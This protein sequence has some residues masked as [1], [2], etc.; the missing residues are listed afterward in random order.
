MQHQLHH[1]K[2]ANGVRVLCIPMPG[3]AAVTATVLFSVG[4]RYESDKQRGLAHFTEHMV[5]KG[6]IN[7]PDAQSIAQA[8]DAVGGEFNAFTSQ[9]Y[10]GF[11]TKTAGEHLELGLSVL[12]DMLLHAQFSQQEL[13]KEKGVIVEEINMYEDMPMRKVD[14]VL[15]ELVYGQTALGLPIIGSKESVTAFTPADFL[16]YR[17]EFY[18]GDAC[19]IV[20][21]G[22]VQPEVAHQLATQFFARM[23]S[24]SAHAADS[25]QFEPS[26][27]PVLI[28]EK[29]SEQTHLLLAVEGL[30]FS[31]PQRYA[32]RVLA[33][34]L[35][36]N[37]S[38]RLFVSVR[39]QQG[40]CYYVRA[41]PDV[42]KDTGMLVASAGVDNNRAE[43]AVQAIVKEMR[44]LREQ[45][46]SQAELQRAKQYMIGKLKLALEDSEQVSEAYGMQMLFD[47]FVEGSQ[48]MIEQTEAVTAE[49]VHALAQSLFVTEKL[50]LAMV[51]PQKAANF[52]SHLVF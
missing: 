41:F 10:T 39:E 11:Y 7:Y 32:Y 27:N 9:E 47:G 40:L 2:L 34:V 5:F 19:L 30:P 28:E 6:G 21:A 38:S 24:G 46:I 18:H 52:I 35:G 25:A 1:T 17:D 31:H 49:E 33:T 43:Q 16:A 44:L 42:Y 15:M 23:P 14:H 22:N 12:S 51:G 4:S 29:S 37:M 20:M 50:R 45:P 26:Q 3:T 13:E 48:K 36:G 8:L